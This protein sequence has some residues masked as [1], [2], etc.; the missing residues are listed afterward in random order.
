M[1]REVKNHEVIIF[2]LDHYNPLGLVRSFGEEGIHSIVV[3]QKSRTDISRYS[4]YTKEYIAVEP[5]P[6]P[7][8]HRAPH[9][10]LL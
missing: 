10:R 8:S 6:H 5:L 2:A 9:S 1:I 3:A 7:A 4:K